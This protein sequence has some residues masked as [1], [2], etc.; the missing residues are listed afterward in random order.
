M[1]QEEHRHQEEAIQAAI[2]EAIQVVNPGGSSTPPGSTPT[3][4]M[5][6][7]SLTKGLG[8]KGLH[9]TSFALSLR[10]LVQNMEHIT[11]DDGVPWSRMQ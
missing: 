6:A 1:S 5:A 8:A 3:S 11:M 2:Q 7:E 10:R 9:S 4:E